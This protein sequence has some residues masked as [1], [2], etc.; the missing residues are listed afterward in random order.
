M[1]RGENAEQLSVTEKTK[2]FQLELAMTSL[3]AVYASL[4]HILAEPCG[5]LEYQ[6]PLESGTKTVMEAIS[7][8]DHFVKTN[9]SLADIQDPH[10][11]FK[12]RYYLAK[13]VCYSVSCK[14]HLLAIEPVLVA[15]A[16]SSFSL[17]YFEPYGETVNALERSLPDVKSLPGNLFAKFPNLQ[18]LILQECDKLTELPANISCCRQL[19]KLVLK[20]SAVQSL[21]DDLFHVPDLMELELRNLPVT[22]IPDKPPAGQWLTRLTL[23]GLQLRE[24]P[25]SLGNLTELVELNLNCNALTDLPMDLQKLQRLRVLHLC[26]QSACSVCSVC[27]WCGGGG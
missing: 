18:V 17:D 27:V 6:L 19:E 11:L 23:S 5:G 22:A 4:C 12:K 3:L 7:H 15:E 16:A 13:K 26:G 8:D 1:L 25:P 24:V 14:A 21:P 2:R 10:C 9:T 20:D